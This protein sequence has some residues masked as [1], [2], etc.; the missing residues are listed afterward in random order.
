MFHTSRSTSIRIICHKACTNTRTLTNC[1]A[2][3]LL[4]ADANLPREQT[5]HSELH[6]DVSN[7]FPYQNPEQITYGTTIWA[8]AT[9]LLAQY[10]TAEAC[11][12]ANHRRIPRWSVGALVQDVTIPANYYVLTTAHGVLRHWKTGAQPWTSVS[13]RTYFVRFADDGKQKSLRLSDRAFGYYGQYNASSS[14]P[15]VL[16]DALAIKIE[17]LHA[18]KQYATFNHIG[19]DTIVR[20][21]LGDFDDVVDGDV[22]QK[23]S[24]NF[25]AVESGRLMVPHTQRYQ[26]RSMIQGSDD[27][28]LRVSG[29]A[30]AP[31]CSGSI[32]FTL[33][34]A[35][36]GRS[37]ICVHG[38]V[39]ATMPAT[40]M[41]DYVSATNVT[42]NT[43][44][45]V[46]AATCIQALNQRF[47]T[48]LKLQLKIYVN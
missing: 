37:V 33:R 44:V 15:S 23:Q 41:L 6:S 13:D 4:C 3:F 40:S 9:S 46:D 19:K 43:L 7:A 17:N 31:G 47:H 8:V 24:R 10:D 48:K 12:A 16:V 32:I 42:V 35:A 5:H 39:H 27:V 29:M 18:F 30:H 11:L 36:N 26:Y 22:V 14:R 1:L 38:L 25:W 2:S 45:A 20:S 21:E 34:P 28:T